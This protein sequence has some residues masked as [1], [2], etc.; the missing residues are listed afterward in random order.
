MK[1]DLLLM[2]NVL[3]LLANSTRMIMRVGTIVYKIYCQINEIN[4]KL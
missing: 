2:L 4:L 1:S 3:L